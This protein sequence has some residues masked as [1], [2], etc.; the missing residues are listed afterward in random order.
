M[1]NNNTLPMSAV[2]RLLFLMNRKAKFES[3]YAV[4]RAIN[5]RKVRA[6]IP[7]SLRTL[8]DIDHEYWSGREV[9]TLSPKAG[10][11]NDTLIYL[12]GGA[13][14]FDLLVPHWQLIE[15]L[16]KNSGVSVVVPIYRLAPQGTVDTEL[17]FVL[18]VYDK[19][20]KQTASKVFVAGDSAGG[21]FAMSLTLALRDKEAKLPDKVFLFSPWL[22]LNT[23]NPDIDDELQAKDPMLMVEGI[24]WCARL[25]ENETDLNSP[26]LSPMFADLTD[27]PPLHIYQGTNDILCPDA[28][29]FAEQVHKQGAKCTLNLYDNAFHVFMALPSILPEAREVLDEVVKIIRG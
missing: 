16:I 6:K 8:C 3:V 11:T 23:D 12:H 15:Y 7:K 21:N 25:W 18:S 2:T 28:K 1:L 13:Y 22:N 9:I 4:E 20:R 10:K 24:R 14:V 26:M 19:V 17:P 27:L 29:K 5:K